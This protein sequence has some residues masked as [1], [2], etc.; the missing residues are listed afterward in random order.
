MMV[1]D[2]VREEIVYQ[3]SEWFTK[4]PEPD[5]QIEQ[6]NKG[7]KRFLFYPWGVFCT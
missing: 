1:T 6:Y 4:A 5:K 3:D 7:R 2:I